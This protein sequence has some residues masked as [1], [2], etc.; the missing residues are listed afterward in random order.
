MGKSRRSTLET[1][2]NILKCA[3][4]QHQPLGGHE[5]GVPFFLYACNYGGREISRVTKFRGGGVGRVDFASD[6]Y[7]EPSSATWS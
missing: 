3:G 4:A 5:V 1:E 7:T 6:N 2:N